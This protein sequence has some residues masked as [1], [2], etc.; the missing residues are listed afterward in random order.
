MRYVVAITGC[1]GIRYGVR[2]LETLDGRISLIVSRTGEK[3]M[4][5]EMGLD[6][7][8]LSPLVENTYEDDDLFAPLSSGSHQFEAMV[9]VP[10]SASTMGKLACGIADTLITRTAG[11]ALKEGRKLILV[12]R[13]TPMSSIMIENELRLSRCGA[14]ILPASPGF[15][16][17]PESIDDLVDFIVGKVLDQLHQKHRLYRRWADSSSSEPL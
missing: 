7:E 9:I 11:V 6:R 5:H 12:P 13:E 17:S 2:L 14:T 10:C 15:Y 4:R 16:H 1:S 8:S 3:I